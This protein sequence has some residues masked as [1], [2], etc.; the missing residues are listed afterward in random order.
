MQVQADVDQSDIGRIKVGEPARFSVDAY[1]DQ[2]FRGQI[3]QV[4]LNATVTQNV[5]TY[6]VMIAVPNPDEK[7][8][9]SMTANVT[10]EVATVPNV[11]RVPNAALR[12]KPDTGAAGKGQAGAAG[13]RAAGTQ[14][15]GG[16]GE[17]GTTTTAGGAGGPRGQGRRPGAAAGSAGAGGTGGSFEGSAADRGASGL[18]G[19]VPEGGRKA[20]AP[21]RNSQTVYVLTETNTLKPISIRTGISDGHY[22]QVVSGDLAPGMKIVTGLATLKVEGGPT[23][24]RPPG[25]G[26]F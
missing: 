2:E 6:P 13:P 16:S 18:A 1:P 12:F 22:T 4:R 3:S 23:S 11:L 5:I 8:R 17:A 26:R 21:R 10:I 7:L 19:A 25:F 14:G 15:T 20:G 24:G 9:P